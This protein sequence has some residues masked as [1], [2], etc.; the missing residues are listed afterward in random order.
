MVSRSRS[1]GHSIDAGCN[2][3]L[4][5]GR[6]RPCR[7]MATGINARLAVCRS[8]ASARRRLYRYVKQPVENEKPCDSIT[9]LSAKNRGQEE[10]QRFNGSFQ[11]RATTQCASVYRACRASAPRYYA[12]FAA[13]TAST[14]GFALPALNTRVP[15]GRLFALDDRHA[16]QR[17]DD[18]TNGA[19]YLNVAYSTCAIRVRAAAHRHRTDRCDPARRV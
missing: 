15:R 6:S 13:R 9:E 11:W 16:G 19:G 14:I 17:C 4:S 8:Y 10:R 2:C 12:A 3:R 18:V 7:I 1:Q 5:S